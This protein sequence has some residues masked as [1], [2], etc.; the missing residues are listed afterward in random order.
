MEEED[1]L[2]GHE[3]GYELGSG[4]CTKGN[5]VLPRPLW[6][7]RRSQ[8]GLGECLWWHWLCRCGPRWRRGRAQR[9]RA[10]P[11]F[12]TESGPHRHSVLGAAQLQPPPLTAFATLRLPPTLCCY[13]AFTQLSVLCVCCQCL[14][15]SCVS[16]S[17]S[18][19]AHR[20]R[21]SIGPCAL[22]DYALTA[23]HPTLQRIVDVHPPEESCG[24]ANGLT[25]PWWS[26]LD[27]A[28]LTCR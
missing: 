14:G 24:L 4:Y 25:R 6:W 18:A 5:P 12:P 22:A 2:N 1:A 7:S 19:V 9:T 20:P 17:L 27:G 16:T 8:D 23:L 15:S 21:R 28:F 11:R 13:P 10:H 3:V 26:L